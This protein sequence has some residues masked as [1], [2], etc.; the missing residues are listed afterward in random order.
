M[1]ALK[2]NEKVLHLLSVIILADKKNIGY[3]LINIFFLLNQNLTWL[4]ILFC[5]FAWIW[6]NLPDQNLKLFC[7]DV[8]NNFC[9]NQA[10][11]VKFR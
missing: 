5:V 10:N 9:S 4:F 2:Q 6:M 3:S 11:S 7:F 8:Q 1:Y